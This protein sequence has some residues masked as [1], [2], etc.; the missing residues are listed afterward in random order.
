[1]QIASVA[2]MKPDASGECRS[3]RAA[4]RSSWPTDGIRALANG[5]VGS[6]ASRTRDTGGV[7]G[8]ARKG[9][10]SDSQWTNVQGHESI[11]VRVAAAPTGSVRHA[12]ATP[13][14]PAGDS[15]RAHH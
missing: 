14:H 13:G 12:T 8:L 3:E 2:T 10:L 11:S 7:F 4:K 5:N 1:M 6:T 15:P 9:H